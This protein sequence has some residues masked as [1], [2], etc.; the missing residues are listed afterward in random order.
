MNELPV[1]SGNSFKWKKGR[2]HATVAQLGILSFPKSFYIRSEKT[3]KTMLFCV[4]N[5]TMESNEFFDGEA[6]AYQDGADL[7]IKVQIWC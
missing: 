5:Q 7:G 6:T 3:G 1:F 2:A 4:D